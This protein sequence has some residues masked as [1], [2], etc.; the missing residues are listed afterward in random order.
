MSFSSTFA[1]SHSNMICIILFISIIISMRVQRTPFP[2][3]MC[4]FKFVQI[5]LVLLGLELVGFKRN[6]FLLLTR[7]RFSSFRVFIL[8]LL[9]LLV[10]L[11][12]APLLRFLIITST[13]STSVTIVLIMLTV[14]AL[15]M[16]KVFTSMP[17]PHIPVTKS[18]PSS[19][20]SSTSPLLPSTET[21]SMRSKRRFPHRSPLS[22]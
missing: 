18:S 12:P 6:P 11:L 3:L 4:T 13:V 8:F 21:R 15:S 1:T 10:F 19:S 16:P 20:S 14:R 5:A 17:L 7:Q 2:I 22:G 9:K